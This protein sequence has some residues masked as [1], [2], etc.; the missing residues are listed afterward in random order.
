MRG[1]V[2]LFSDDAGRTIRF[3][4]ERAVNPE[5]VSV[6]V[7][8]FSDFLLRYFVALAA[9]GALAM[10]LIELYK[11]LR[12][13]RTRYHA[14]HLVSWLRE[15]PEN[16]ALPDQA[17][18]CLSELLQLTS[19][20]A[21]SRT[22]LA[23]RQLMTSG[24]ALPGLLTVPLRRE[25]AVFALELDK[26]M[27]HVQDAIDIALTDPKAYPALFQFI[28][29]GVSPDDVSL[30]QAFVESAHGDSGPGTE[31]RNA[32]RDADVYT[33]L[34]QSARRRLDA[35]QLYCSQRWATGNQFWAN[36]VG[37]VVLGSA[38]WWMNLRGTD[39]ATTLSLGELLIL[40]LAGGILA[41]V[42][43]DMVAAL[44]RVRGG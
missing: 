28:T 15:T 17:D 23:A 11:K 34:Q 12:D 24:G 37:V 25:H 14:R 10:A 38:L 27:G 18:N 7:T 8:A 43:K 1:I 44:Q 19:G 5:G 16:A 3:F 29:A 33:R 40:S 30:W 26:M 4:K 21:R 39:A 20:L 22:D 13:A 31:S 9:V 32:R 36:V 41:P 2:D 6:A 35:F 42:A